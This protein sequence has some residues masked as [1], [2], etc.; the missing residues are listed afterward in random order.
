M[1]IWLFVVVAWQ[2]C[3]FF[4]DLLFL[5]LFCSSNQVKE[6]TNIQSFDEQMLGLDSGIHNRGKPNRKKS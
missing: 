2:A 1:A 3:D 4:F 5:L 6:I